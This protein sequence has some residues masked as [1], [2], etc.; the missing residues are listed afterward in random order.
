MFV[1]NSNTSGQVLKIDS[2]K[3]QH[4]FAEYGKNLPRNI[5]NKLMSESRIVP[6]DSIYNIVSKF[7]DKKFYNR[8]IVGVHYR[9][10]DKSSE[11]VRVP[12]EYVSD[13]LTKYNRAH[14][15]VATDE[16]QFL[17]FMRERHGSRVLHYDSLRSKDCTPIH[18]FASDLDKYRVGEDALVDCLLLS[19]CHI[20]LRTES[21]LSQACS[22]FNP[23]LDVVSI[24]KEYLASC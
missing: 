13:M 1:F 9:G 24:T 3:D 14:F 21:N 20:L 22:F 7:I 16:D 23:K 8:Q 11:S 18:L 4:C 19:K 2:V 12:Y 5:A 6:N 15:F 17:E 10:T